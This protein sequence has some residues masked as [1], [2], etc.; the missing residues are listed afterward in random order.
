MMETV[1]TF[2]VWLRS[3]RRALDLTQAELARRVNCAQVTI[4]KLEA[5]QLKPSS[6]LA[7]SLINQL[8]IPAL[9]RDALIKFSRGGPPPVLSPHFL[10]K[11]N[12]PA[13]LTS[14]IGREREMVEVKRLLR[15]SR[16]VTLTGDGGVGKTRLSIQVGMEL[17]DQFFDG[18]WFVEFAP[19]ANLDLLPGVILSIF[20]L[21]DQPNKTTLETLQDYLQNMQVLL[22]LDNCE[23]VIDSAAKL[24]LALLENSPKLEILAT[25]REALNVMGEIAWRLPSLS[26]PDIKSLSET[27]DQLTQYESVRLFIERA[28]LVSSHFAVNKENAPAIAQVCFHLDGIPLALELAAARIRTMT[29]EQI[30]DHLDDRFQLLTDGN[31]TALPRQQTLRALIDWSYN[32]LSDSERRILAR[33]SVFAGGWTAASAKA[34]CTGDGIEPADT[35]ELLSQL[36]N[37]SLVVMEHEQH[38]EARYRLL[39]TIRQYAQ[40]RLIQFGELRNT[41]LRHLE[42][43]AKLVEEADLNFKSGNQAV[44]YQRLDDEVDDLRVA[45]SWPEGSEKSEIRLR[46]GAGLWRYWKSR[47]QIREGQEHLRRLLEGQPD[48]QSRRTSDYAMALNAA[49]ALA[50][51][52]ADFSFSEQVRRSAL[53][54]FR[55]LDDKVGTA[56]CLNGLGN[57]AIS[58]ANYESA[59]SYYEEGL[60]I[61]KELGDRW[62]V[63]RLLGNLGLLAYFQADYA[64]ARRFHLESIALFNELEDEE[65]VASELNNLGDVARRQEDLSTARDYHEQSSAIYLKL[66]D[67]WGLAYSLKGMADVAFE[68]G[69]IATAASLYRECLILFQ[70]VGDNIAVPY[71]FETIAS[72]MLVKDKPLKTALLFGAADAL[73]KKINCPLHS[74]ELADHNKSMSLLRERLD[75]SNLET[76]WS[77]GYSMTL[78]QAVKYILKES[79]IDILQ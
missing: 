42:F 34:V 12:L 45:L 73:R 3:R 53:E 15:I 54:I 70:K 51:F 26:L 66:K 64:Q 69:D 48:D 79:Q 55:I 13:K 16:L 71:V 7:V 8:E 29:V 10:P 27:A 49:G 38:D 21:N 67:Q 23:H 9:E 11:N 20:K 74:P 46:F 24:A 36:V 52:G 57:V 59:R 50:Y 33:L 47:G 62:G 19:I 1:Q 6:S 37:K 78:D 4:K 77:E 40:E 75:P 65:G 76:A 60:G 68:Q 56:N 32:L 35:L 72:L 58:Q 14:F 2:G 25:S 17:L 31:R 30:N 63:A 22:I 39:E 61:R 18:V 5:D 28:A 44:W 41:R 43:F